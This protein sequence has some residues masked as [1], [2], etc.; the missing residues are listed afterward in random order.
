MA[1]HLVKHWKGNRASYNTVKNAGLLDAWTN[2]VV[3]END[4]T[5]NE[6]FGN[7][8]KFRPEG[9][10][11]TVKDILAAE[12]DVTAVTP[13]DRYLVGTDALGYKVV[14]YTFDKNNT[15]TKEELTFD[16]K[17][18]V[19]VESRGLK[20]YVYYNNKLVTYDDVDC[21]EF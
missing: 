9:Q 6:Y 21:G 12:P 5:V 18:G 11:V 19:R 20:N 14:E 15:L 7:N 10:L 1:K 17:F 16:K 4:G 13:Y 8:L 3:I 2:Y